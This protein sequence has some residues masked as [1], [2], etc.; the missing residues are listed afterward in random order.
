MHASARVRSVSGSADRVQSEND[1]QEFVWFDHEFDLA[2]HES[3][4]RTSTRRRGCAGCDNAY[5]PGTPDVVVAL[6]DGGIQRSAPARSIR[7]RVP[8]ANLV[9]TL[10]KCVRFDRNGSLHVFSIFIDDEKL[11]VVRIGFGDEPAVHEGCHG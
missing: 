4:A 5:S 6:N 9:L 11:L 3:P 1:G 10:L 2:R 7:L 8:A